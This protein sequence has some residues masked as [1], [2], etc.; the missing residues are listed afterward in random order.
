M[1]SMWQAAAPSLLM[2]AQVLKWQRCS[3]TIRLIKV[4]ALWGRGKQHET[5]QIRTLA[6]HSAWRRDGLRSSKNAD[7]ERE[8]GG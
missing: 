6:H 7:T 2:V 4:E 5:A 3:L 8:F 1:F